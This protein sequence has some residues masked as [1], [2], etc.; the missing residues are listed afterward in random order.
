MAVLLSINSCILKKVENFLASDLNCGHNK[1]LLVG[2]ENLI[3]FELAQPV[4]H[5]AQLSEG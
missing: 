5:R 4:P 1:K 3:L 2:Y